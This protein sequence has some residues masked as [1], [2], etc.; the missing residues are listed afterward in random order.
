MEGYSK[1][2]VVGVYKLSIDHEEAFAVILSCKEWG[3]LFLPIFI[4]PPEALA[5]HMALEGHKPKRP[6]TH[7]LIINILDNLGVIVEKVTIDAV[8]DNL[9]VAT[10]VL[11]DDN[12]KRWYID[13]RPSD[14]I[15][16]ALRVNAPIYVANRL[17][18]YAIPEEE[19]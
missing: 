14:S 18:D 11:R 4:G 17:R 7:D 16:I 9:F 8:V 1:A 5:I 10:I 2:R 19:F 15:A 12:G 3:N 13:A 6:L